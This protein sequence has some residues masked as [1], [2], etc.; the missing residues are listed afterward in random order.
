LENNYIKTGYQNIEKIE[1]ILIKL[2]TTFDNEE[3]NK[4]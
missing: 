2:G 3:L 1:K 4:I